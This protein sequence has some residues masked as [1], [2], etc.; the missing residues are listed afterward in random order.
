M[1][2]AGTGGTGRAR[3]I[4]RAL[5][6]ALA[7]CLLIAAA[8]MLYLAYADD[9]RFKKDQE[10]LVAG[11]PV[12]TTTPSPAATSPLDFSG[13]ESEDRAYWEGLKTG[14]SFAR[15]V[16]GEAG[17]DDVVVKGAEDAQLARAPGWIVQTDMPG[18]DG[19]CAISGHR[20]THGHPFRDMDK[21]V[22]GSTVYLYSPFRYYRYEVDR[23]LRVRPSQVEVIA[24]T[25]EP[26]LTL[27]TCDPP[28]SDA[29]RLVVQARLVQVA[30]IADPQA[31]GIPGP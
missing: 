22:V 19:N 21:L 29:K 12:V 13:W 9:L 8:A 26:H 6:Y 30:R 7:F 14:G 24:H 4:V 10:G 18:P 15:I 20:V 1:S 5:L 28:G 16:A 31:G 17:I 11:M 3:R 2:E 27:T 25:E 23:I